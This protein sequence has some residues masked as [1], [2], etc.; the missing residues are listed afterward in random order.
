MAASLAL[1]ASGCR[2]ERAPGEIA[3]A[4]GAAELAGSGEGSGDSLAL[5]LGRLQH[6]FVRDGELLLPPQTV[7]LVDARFVDAPFDLEGGHCYAFAGWGEPVSSDFDL[8]LTTPGGAAAA[9]DDAPDH[10]PVIERFCPAEGGTFNLRVSR[11]GAG[12]R[13]RVG[14]WLLLDGA[15]RTAE[16][17]IEAA[18]A[19]LLEAVEA[20]PSGRIQTTA[21]VEGRPFEVAVAMLPGRCYAVVAI[22]A[23]VI[24]LDL[25]LIGADGVP[26]MRDLST[27]GSPVLQPY[28]P[29]VGAAFRI[30]LKAY[31][32]TGRVWWQVYETNAPVAAPDPEQ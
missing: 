12:G 22:S 27:E 6:L 14:A 16:R 1:V 3:A 31:H 11:G 19:R 26:V 23:E 24:D 9:W 15:A 29:A 2:S 8:R 28:C 21:I 10:F 25:E 13:V 17:E 7:D 5:G 18:R 20:H 4:L 32:G 30:R